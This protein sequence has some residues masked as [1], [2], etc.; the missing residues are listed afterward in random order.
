MENGAEPTCPRR[1]LDRTT[2]TI[3]LTIAIFAALS[4]TCA[5]LSDGFVAADACT[6]YLYARYAFAD[7]VNLVDV[8]AR[9]FVTALFAIPAHL[10]GR[11]GVRVT[12]LLIA[13]GC[14]LVAWRIARGQGHRRPELAMLLTLGQPLLFVYSFGEM[15]ELPFALLLGAAFLAYQNR[16]WFWAALLIGLTP[17]ARPEGFGFVALAAVGLLVQRRW[18]VLPVLMLPLLAWDVGGWMLTA[19]VGPW[20]HWLIAA[21]PWSEAGMYGRGNIL[22]YVAALPVIVSPL[23]LPATAI[24][25]AL[26]LREGAR[27]AED[28]LRACRFLTAAIPLF[29][30]VVHSLLRWLGKFGSFGEPRYLLVVAP[31]WG[32]LSAAGWEWAFERLKWKHPVRWA[33]AAALVPIVVNAIHPAVP[34]RLDADWKTARQFA[35]WYRKSSL[36]ERFPNVIASHPGIF[37]FLDANPTGNNRTGGFTRG[38][39][40]SPPRGAVLVWDPIFSAKNASTEDATTLAA[41]QA[42]GW[43]ARPDIDAMLNRSGAQ[44]KPQA[45]TAPAQDWHVFVSPTERSTHR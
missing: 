25:T 31:F 32:V 5:L 12:S 23:V 44:G 1:T 38:L 20:W 11:M 35:D 3:A 29:V 43:I 28:H 30:L 24:G 2:R 6:H 7:P 33:A 40:G 26:D 22:S 10:G 45:P 36:R 34:I 18:A 42:A 17:T 41:I 9:P 13:I 19:R 8:W 16:R 15:T 37:Y 4:L 39:I 27:L 21:W 14:G